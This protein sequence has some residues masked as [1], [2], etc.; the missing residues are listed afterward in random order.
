MMVQLRIRREVEQEAVIVVDVDEAEFA[1]WSG[2]DPDVAYAE[3][4]EADRDWPDEYVWDANWRDTDVTSF[5]IY[6]ST[7]VQA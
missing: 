3:F 1:E 4:L 6:D 7:K 5:V 2:G